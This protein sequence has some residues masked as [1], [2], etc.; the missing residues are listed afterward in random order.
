MSY[1]LG[2]AES[3]NH[4]DG[5]DDEE[6]FD[7]VKP[8]LGGVGVGVQFDGGDEGWRETTLE[9]VEC[10]VPIRVWPGNTAFKPLDVVFDV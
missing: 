5:E 3:E 4:D 8:I 7:G 9:T 1:F 10:E 6:D 2:S